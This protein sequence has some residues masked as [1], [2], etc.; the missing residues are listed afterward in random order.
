MQLIISNNYE[1]RDLYANLNREYTN[2]LTDSDCAFSTAELVEWS[3]QIANGMTHLE[4]KKV[5]HADLACRNILLYDNNVVKITD[6]GLS[7]QLYAYTNYMKK[8]QEPLPWR[9][10]A[11]E[12]LREMNFSTQSDVWGYGVTL[13]E[14]FSLGAVPY[15]GLSW[16]LDFVEKLSSGLRLTKPFYCTTEM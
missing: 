8:Q 9:W 4:E 16:S 10:M 1:S 5:V 13:W 6:F 15:P 14:L 3:S 2:L 7:R 12:S 11:I